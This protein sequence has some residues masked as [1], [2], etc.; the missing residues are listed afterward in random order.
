M[1]G[2]PDRIL[3]GA[4][5]SARSDRAIDRAVQLARQHGAEL[6][7]LH[8]M[9]GG[10]GADEVSWGHLT[11]DTIKARVLRELDAGGVDV[12]VALAE[13]RASDALLKVADERG[14]GLIVV[15]VSRSDPFGRSQLGATTERVISRAHAPVLVVKDRD[16]GPYRSM[17]AATDFSDSSM[18]ALETA[19]GYFPSLEATLFHAYRVPYEGF[20]SREGSGEWFEAEDDRERQ[21]FMDRL[22]LTPKF[23][24]RMKVVIE[25]GSIHELLDVYVRS[26]GV[27]LAV[28]G[29]HG[30][31]GIFDIPLGNEVKGLVASIPCDMLVVPEP[32]ALKVRKG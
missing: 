22:K 30:R 3:L 6:V 28:A 1:T 32:R 17:V 13:G 12:T 10:Q 5:L 26:A 18:H 27:D 2:F 14:C 20:T 7:A 29:T 4:D 9:E 21:A 15:G 16:H 23:R 11:P 24:E 19:A 8:V 25:Y 31:S